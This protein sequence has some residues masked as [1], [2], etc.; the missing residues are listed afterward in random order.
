M[1]LSRAVG[2]HS[3]R[4]KDDFH[5]EGAFAHLLLQCTD[6]TCGPHV[7]W[8]TTTRSSSARH[9]EMTTLATSVRMD[10]WAADLALRT[11]M[12]RSAVVA[13]SSPSTP[14]ASWRISSADGQAERCTDPSARRYQTA[15]VTNGRTGAN[16]HNS[17]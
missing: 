12:M 16:R 7:S 17:A 1:P 13:S 8:T 9:P 4:L 10:T 3:A 6:T 15:S 14:P 5:G 11:T 2:A